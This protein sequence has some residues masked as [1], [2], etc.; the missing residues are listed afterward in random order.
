MKGMYI[1]G[2][3]CSKKVGQC[4]MAHWEIPFSYSAVRTTVNVR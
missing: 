3:G 1:N 2:I 4:A